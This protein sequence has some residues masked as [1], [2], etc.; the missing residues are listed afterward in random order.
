MGWLRKLFLME[1]KAPAC[2]TEHKSANA[3]I[4]ER[5]EYP[6]K[7]S[8]PDYKYT[9]T[10]YRCKTCGGTW[11]DK[12]L[13]QKTDA[14]LGDGYVAIYATVHYL[15]YYN[16]YD[17]TTRKCVMPKAFTI[18]AVC[19]AMEGKGPLITLKSR[20]RQFNARFF[21]AGAHGTSANPFIPLDTLIAD[22]AEGLSVEAFKLKY[23]S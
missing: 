12:G 16:V 19:D 17:T 13:E 7:S 21:W 8:D 5:E 1:P 6:E 23:L 11:V 3:T 4:V 22:N 20:M 18:A 15:G 10:T 2:A 9:I 14:E